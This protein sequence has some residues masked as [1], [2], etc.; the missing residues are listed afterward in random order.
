MRLPV[1][2]S[3]HAVHRP[4]VAAHVPDIILQSTNPRRPGGKKQYLQHG[5][6]QMIDGGVG[7]PRQSPAILRPY[8]GFMDKMQ[9]IELVGIATRADSTI[10]PVLEARMIE[11]DP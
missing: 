10:D 9:F 3:P 2:A 6:L 4:V 11:R 7:G 8:H 1:S 5:I